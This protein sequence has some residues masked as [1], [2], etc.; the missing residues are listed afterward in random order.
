MDQLLTRLQS[1]YL[2]QCDG[3]W[4]HSFGVKINTLDN[5]GWGLTIDLKETPLEGKEFKTVE[6]GLEDDDSVDWHRVWVENCKFEGRGDASKLNF[7][8]N[9]FLNWAG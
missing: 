6:R 8:L 3:D 9:A 4:E 5:P 7:L 2:S 1:W